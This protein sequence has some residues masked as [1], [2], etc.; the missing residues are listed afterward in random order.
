MGLELSN[1]SKRFVIW[2]LYF[3]IFFPF[4]FTSELTLHKASR[5]HYNISQNLLITSQNIRNFTNFHNLR[6]FLQQLFTFNHCKFKLLWLNIASFNLLC[7]SVFHQISKFKSEFQI[8]I[9]KPIRNILKE[10]R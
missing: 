1:F 6:Y 4:N 7:F 8:I 5:T 9:F 2:I 3:P 10:S